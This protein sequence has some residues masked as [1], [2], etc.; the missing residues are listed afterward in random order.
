MAPLR[1]PTPFATDQAGQRLENEFLSAL[2]LSIEAPEGGATEQ[3]AWAE[4][5]AMHRQ[6]IAGMDDLAPSLMAL[7]RWGIRRLA[8]EKI[9]A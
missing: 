9:P 3:Q 8:A 2:E 7:L 4:I 5:K 6:A 1:P